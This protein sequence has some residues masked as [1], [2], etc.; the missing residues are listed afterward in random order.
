MYIAVSVKDSEMSKTGINE[1]KTLESLRDKIANHGREI[2]DEEP[3][4]SQGG[5]T[6]RNERVLVVLELLYRQAV[7]N[8]NITAGREYLDRIL[9]KPKENLSLDN[10]GNPFQSYT[11]SDILSRVVDIVKSIGDRGTETAP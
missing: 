1:K 11:D 9:G 2:V 4:W 7:D 5:R 3:A 8:K 10:A 6:V